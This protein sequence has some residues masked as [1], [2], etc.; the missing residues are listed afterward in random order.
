[1]VYHINDR[2]SILFDKIIINCILDFYV[3]VILRM[4]GA[5][6]PTQWSDF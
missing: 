5:K 3:H 1:M 2:W 4:K 6:R